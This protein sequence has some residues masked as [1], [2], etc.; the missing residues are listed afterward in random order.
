MRACYAADR[1][2]HMI[3]QTLYQQCIKQNVEFYNEF[4]VLDLLMTGG[5]VAGVVAYEL[6]TGDLHVFQ[7]KSVVFATGGF[8][9]VFKTTSNALSLTGDGM[10]VVWRQRIAARGHGVLPV[11]SHGPGRARHPAHRGRPR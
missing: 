4:Y 2:G 1:T 10:G 11:P 8:G 3:L 6:A 5:E 7:A 9:R